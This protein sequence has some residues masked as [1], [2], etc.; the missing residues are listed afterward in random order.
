MLSTDREP[1]QKV[2]SNNTTTSTRRRLSFKKQ[3]KSSKSNSSSNNNSNNNDYD[4]DYDLTEPIVAPRYSSNTEAT[5]CESMAGTTITSDE[6]TSSNSNSNTMSVSETTNTTGG[7]HGMVVG[8]ESTASTTVR[9]PAADINHHHHTTNA[10]TT[11]TT[12]DTTVAT[13]SGAC[14]SSNNKNNQEQQQEEESTGSDPIYYFGYGPIVNPLVR[15]RRG[16]TIPTQQIETAILYDHRLRFVEGGTANIVPARGW[17]VKGVLLKFNNADEWNAFQQ[18]DSNYDVK[19][20]SVS[21]MNKTNQDP[22][23]KNARIFPLEDD[24][25]DQDQDD[26]GN[27]H[28]VEDAEDNDETNDGANDG[29]ND[30]DS[31]SESDLLRN[32]RTYNSCPVASSSGNNSDGYASEEYSCPFGLGFGGESTTREDDPNAVRCFTF[33]ID[34]QQQGPLF[35]TSSASDPNNRCCKP[36]ERYLKL[37]ADGLRAHEVDENY[38]RDEILMVGYVSTE[39]DRVVDQNYKTFPLPTATTKRL[40]KISFS[41]YESK[42]C[43]NSNNSKS[44]STYF[45][46][47]RKVIRVDPLPTT[48]ATTSNFNNSNNACLRWIRSVGH[49]KGDLTLLVH[50]TFVDPDCSPKL[51]V[52][53]NTEDLTPEHHRW[54]EHTLF[55]YLERGGLTGT[56]VHELSST[57]RDEHVSSSAS[58]SSFGA[59]CKTVSRRFHHLG[60]SGNVSSSGN[61]NGN[62]TARNSTGTGS[63]S[64]K[65]KRRSSRR[66]ASGAVDIPTLL[67]E[68][69]THEKFTSEMTDE[70]AEENTTKE[71][72]NQ[73]KSERKGFG[74]LFKSRRNK[75]SSPQYA[76]GA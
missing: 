31:D 52:V 42:L 68:P 28:Q 33:A 64:S 8:D 15:L 22:K 36:Q 16:C 59:L 53:D 20:V 43:S 4:Y 11:A 12:V 56:V 3:R 19:E 23:N 6:F 38:I 71:S 49:G 57:S 5:V 25:Q 48:A 55:L 47:D 41:K 9:S 44:E 40:P 7:V 61:G 69:F 1:E 75:N 26:G 62:S 65:G 27:D 34:H 73:H 46:C 21:I 70:D 29:A 60:R 63:Q 54:A 37:I 18:Y 72:N 58:A 45:V 32:P 39:S 24:D 74:G 35:D 51:S 67:K 17:D 2:N 30:E 10:C 66:S 50:Q 76:P 14:S 13:T